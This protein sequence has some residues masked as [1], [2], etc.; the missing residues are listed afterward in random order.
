MEGTELFLQ[1][2]SPVLLKAP[3]VRSKPLFPWLPAEMG[4]SV[5]K[6]IPAGPSQSTPPHDPAE[7]MRQSL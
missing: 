7:G 1:I 5:Q 4:Y 2:P 3:S 6:L